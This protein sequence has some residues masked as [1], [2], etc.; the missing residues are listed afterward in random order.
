[1]ITNFFSSPHKDYF[2]L[3][4]IITLCIYLFLCSKEDTNCSLH[5]FLNSFT[6]SVNPYPVLGHVATGLKKLNYYYI[7]LKS[8]IKIHYGLFVH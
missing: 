5:S 2:D 7:T 1:M 4:P 3:M 6:Y 8:I